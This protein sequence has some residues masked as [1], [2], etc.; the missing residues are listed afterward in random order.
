MGYFS[1]FLLLLLLDYLGG[2]SC[3]DARNTAIA[4]PIDVDLGSFSWYMHADFRSSMPETVVQVQFVAEELPMITALRFCASLDSA[5]ELTDDISATSLGSSH[6]L[7]VRYMQC[8]RSL[9]LQHCK[10][11]HEL[12]LIRQGC[13]Q[14]LS[15]EAPKEKYSGGKPINESRP[16]ANNFSKRVLAAEL[17]PFSQRCERRLRERGLW[18]D[19]RWHFPPPLPDDNEWRVVWASLSAGCSVAA[20]ARG[21]GRL[22]VGR[23]YHP[24]GK[25][26]SANCDAAVEWDFLF[27]VVL[28][29]VQVRPESTIAPQQR[30]KSTNTTS[31]KEAWA[32]PKDAW[33]TLGVL[34]ERGVYVVHIASHLGRRWRRRVRELGEALEICGG[35]A[36]VTGQSSSLDSS[37]TEWSTSTRVPAAA[38]VHLSDEYGT[39]DDFYEPWQLILRQYFSPILARRW[40]TRLL[41]LPLGYTAGFNG[42]G[43]PNR[44]SLVEGTESSK[45]R[46]AWAF[47]GNIGTG[48][49]PTRV[50]FLEAFTSEEAIQ[51]L[52]AVTG[53]LTPV[54]HVRNETLPTGGLCHK[55]ENTVVG[56]PWQVDVW[57]ASH[58]AAAMQQAVFCPAP[59]GFTAPDSYR[60]WEAM[61]SGCFPL[62]DAAI[63][64]MAHALEFNDDVLGAQS[65]A[66]RTPPT[67]ENGLHNGRQD[68]F[69]RAEDGAAWDSSTA[70]FQEDYQQSGGQGLLHH[71][72][73]FRLFL[74]HIAH[75][76]GLRSRAFTSGGSGA[77]LEWTS[78]LMLVP[79]F[80]YEVKNGDWVAA[81]SWVASQL[82]Q[83]KRN[84]SF[85]ELNE[86]QK[87]MVGWWTHLKEQMAETV[88]SR[89][90]NLIDV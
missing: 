90:A 14:M 58:V 87:V 10:E 40:K 63:V 73:Y 15:S 78:L 28:K 35:H 50:S 45:R 52:G 76:Y 8:A 27:D 1:N 20:E 25:P 37:K 2:S 48:R 13:Y 34:V 21:D 44:S 84:N 6:T 77:D 18:E 42:L 82:R 66:W 39:L 24:V 62:V 54:T 23:P 51:T 86:R 31:E 79:H 55:T 83:D 30:D 29:D 88:S 49:K 22:E 59:I 89:L 9:A 43:P 4:N 67:T 3:D 56:L 72:F 65:T 11:C 61:E 32:P 75:A 5:D 33:D 85:Q 71:P 17:E 60:F 36:S 70:D 80:F 38:L 68:Y 19:G 41:F 26:L 57:P 53:T 16:S 74:S 64:T 46:F 81:K 47:S 69:F 12:G 7:G